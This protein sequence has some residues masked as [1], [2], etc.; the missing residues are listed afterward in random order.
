MTLPN[1]ETYPNPEQRPHP[2]MQPMPHH[3]GLPGQHPMPPAPR[4][5]VELQRDAAAAMA[6][7]RELGPDFDD[8]IAAG[9]AERMEQ[10]A[11]HR[12]VEL[13]EQHRASRV[14]EAAERSTRTQ[15]FALGIVSLGAGIPITAISAGMVDPPLI[16]VLV[17]WGGIVAVNVVHALGGRRRR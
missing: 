11:Y 10:L 16:G 6:A 12:G 8:Q 17:S 15:R 2:T 5:S 7:R 13:Q 3:P 9:L 14:E 4:P 1:P